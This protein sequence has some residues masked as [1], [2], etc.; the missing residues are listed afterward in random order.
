M[1]EN[2]EKGETNDEK[3]SQKQ[4][5]SFI[6]FWLAFESLVGG[7]GGS[8]SFSHSHTLAHLEH[9]WST[10]AFNWIGERKQGSIR[11]TFGSSTTTRILCW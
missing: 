5:T 2:E 6:S 4:F 7:E 1:K 9:S 8:S 3:A 10:L 11:G